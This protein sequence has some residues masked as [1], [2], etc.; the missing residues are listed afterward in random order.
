[1]RALMVAH[2]GAVH[3]GHKYGLRACT[4]VQVASSL[5]PYSLK[6]LATTSRS[7]TVTTLDFKFRAVLSNDKG[8]EV[9][10]NRV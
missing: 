2:T 8:I 1:M 5:I 6:C 7:S 9:E 4:F 3:V 10:L